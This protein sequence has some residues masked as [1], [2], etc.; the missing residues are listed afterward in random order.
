MFKELKN[1]IGILLGQAVLISKNHF[2]KSVVFLS[3]F[4]NQK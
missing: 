4:I 2:P 3:R 1:G